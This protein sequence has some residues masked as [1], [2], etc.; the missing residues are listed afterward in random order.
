[1]RGFHDIIVTTD[2]MSIICLFIVNGA[3]LNHNVAHIRNMGQE[4][5]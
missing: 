2:S 5:K 3:V 4:V 1:M